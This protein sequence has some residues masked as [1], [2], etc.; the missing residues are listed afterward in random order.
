M[1]DKEICK[2][3]KQEKNKTKTNNSELIASEKI[4]SQKTFY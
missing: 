3:I 1:N 4:L 2:L